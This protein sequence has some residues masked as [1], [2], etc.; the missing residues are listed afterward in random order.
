M[1]RIPL[2]TGARVSEM[3]ALEKADIV[4][5]GLQIDESALKGRRH[6]PR[7]GRSGIRRFQT[8][9]AESWSSGPRPFRFISS[10]RPLSAGC[11]AETDL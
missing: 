1:R 10:S 7:T 2:L 11:R 8:R 5:A 6:T 3:L 4:P 9:S